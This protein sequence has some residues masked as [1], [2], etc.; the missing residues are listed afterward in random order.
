MLGYAVAKLSLFL[1]DIG[2]IL[3]PGASFYPFLLNLSLMSSS[4]ATKY[5]AEVMTG[6]NK[7]LQGYRIFGQI[8]AG[9]CD[10]V[11]VFIHFL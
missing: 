8:L 11:R 7:P 5:L 1:A 6:L 10:Q 2:W 9:S 3:C 4:L